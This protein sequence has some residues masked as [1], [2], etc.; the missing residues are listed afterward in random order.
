MKHYFKQMMR[1]LQLNSTNNEPFYAVC[2]FII[3]Q[4]VFTGD[5]KIRGTLRAEIKISLFAA[6][7]Y[8]YN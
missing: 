4:K 2:S 6:N 5:G 7:K 3:I 8:T 1:K